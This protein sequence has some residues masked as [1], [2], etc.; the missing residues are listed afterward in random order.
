LDEVRGLLA[1]VMAEAGEVPAHLQ[2]DDR[3]RQDEADPEPARHVDQ[4][5]VRFRFGAD[6]NR[7][8]RHAADRARTR[9]HL[10]DLG[11]HRAGV[12]GSF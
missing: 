8:Q 12:D 3:K 9:P 10:P 5:V 7:F 4:F 11:M 6:Q 1:D 2:R